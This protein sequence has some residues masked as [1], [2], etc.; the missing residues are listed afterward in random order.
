MF[1]PIYFFL[2]RICFFHFSKIWRSFFYKECENELGFFFYNEYDGENFVLSPKTANTKEKKQKIP[3]SSREKTIE[4]RNPAI[5]PASHYRKGYNK[6]GL[7]K[8][9]TPLFFFFKIFVFVFR[10][11]VFCC[12]Y[13]LC[14]FLF[15]VFEH[16]C[17]NM[18]IQRKIT[19]KIQEYTQHAHAQ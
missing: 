17:K 12:V 1:R 5:E 13:G 4:K 9:Q 16:K 3:N 15:C 8:K 11:C 6:D 18:N 10:C 2:K 14:T 7:K 19:K